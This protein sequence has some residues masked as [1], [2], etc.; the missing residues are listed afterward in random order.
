MGALIFFL[1]KLCIINVYLNVDTKGMLKRYI[2]ILL[3]NA[4][5]YCTRVVHVF[6]TYMLRDGYYS[7]FFSINTC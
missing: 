2:C 7:N 3:Q 1:I 4:Y 6:Y 5:R